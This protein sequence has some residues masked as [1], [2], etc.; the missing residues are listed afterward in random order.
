MV[1]LE[2]STLI[3][4]P[5]T[6]CFDLARSVEVHLLRN[7]HFGEEST[8]VGGVTSGLLGLGDIVT[9]QAR[10]LFVRQRLTNVIT[11]YEF[12]KYFQATM[13]EGAFQFMQHDHL[14]EALSQ[15]ETKMTDVLRFSAPLPILGQIAEVCVLRRYMKRLLLERNA[16]IKQV[17][18]S[19]DWRRYVQGLD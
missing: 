2:E 5:R 9:W 1:T 18:E 10:H 15:N 6:R 16:V 12:P 11:T 8:A 4:A 13:T 17:A 14:F 7:T 19:Q 3:D